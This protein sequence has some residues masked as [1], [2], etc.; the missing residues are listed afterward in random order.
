MKPSIIHV[1]QHLKPGGIENFALE[2]QR[3]AAPFFDVHVISLEKC[4]LHYSKINDG[5]FYDFIHVLD[6]EPGWQIKT[7]LKLT[8]IIKEINPLYVHTHHIGPLIYGGLAARLSSVEN[9]IHTEHDAWHLTNFKRRT[10]QQIFLKLV[11]PIFVADANFVACQ[12]KKLLP[13]IK[14]IVITNGIDENKF[15]PAKI[16]KTTLLEQANLPTYLTFIGCA[17]RLEPVKSHHVLIHALAKLPPDIGLLLAG[18]GSLLLELKELV[19]KLKLDKRVFFLGHIEDMSSFYPLLDVFCLS[20]SNEGLPLSPL[21]AQACNIP[22]VLT[23]VGGC[24][25]AICEY[26]GKLVK[27]NDSTDL[28]QALL[29][30]LK[31]KRTISPRVFI[32]NER[33]INRM[34]R[35]YISLTQTD[36]R[37][38]L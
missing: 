32:K 21:E 17:A 3:A 25:E 31:E 22:V 36:L 20:S 30:T 27:P 14:P 16:D 11:A 33:S 10:L 2:F 34:I 6:K 4:S 37:G 23:D 8:K 7:L 29:R 12:V 9:I 18:T 5:Q 26:T 24:R 28:S 35:Q 13:S 1:V 15:K 19:K 38:K